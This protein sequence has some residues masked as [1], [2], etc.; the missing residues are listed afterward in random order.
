MIDI[1]GEGRFS[2]TIVGSCKHLFCNFLSMLYYYY[3][4]LKDIVAA[5]KV[6]PLVHLPQKS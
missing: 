3:R 2:L 1:E 4:Y 6:E 5:F